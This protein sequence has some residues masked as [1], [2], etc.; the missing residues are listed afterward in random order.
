MCLGDDGSYEPL[1]D[2]PAEG[3][4]EAAQ[5]PPIQLQCC[6]PDE[7]ASQQLQ[8]LIANHVPQETSRRIRWVK[9]MLGKTM[10]LSGYAAT[11]PF[12]RT[13]SKLI[14]ARLFA[15]FILELCFLSP[16]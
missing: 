3:S 4:S 14:A 12:K 15:A 1:V 6:L 13:A 11:Q 7:A 10:I 8:Q 16:H 5:N 9:E 2:A